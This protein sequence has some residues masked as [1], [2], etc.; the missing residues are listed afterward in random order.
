MDLEQWLDHIQRWCAKH[1]RWMILIDGRCGSGK[2]TIA[3]RMVQPLNAYCIHMDDYYLPFEKRDHQPDFPGNHMD[4]QRLQKQVIEPFIQNGKFDSI[5]YDAHQDH[6][7]QITLV[8]TNGLIIEGS[9]SMFP[10]LVYPHDTLK[11]FITIDPNVQKQR[12][13]ARGGM[14]CWSGFE[15]RWIPTEESYFKMYSI[16]EKA[17]M[18]LSFDGTTI[19]IHSMKTLS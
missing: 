19:S 2:T 3:Q 8:K 7:G 15:Q 16:Q 6:Y 10:H 5:P 18:V 11:L 14:A 17:D 4:Y 12:I 13:I 1:P 9:Y